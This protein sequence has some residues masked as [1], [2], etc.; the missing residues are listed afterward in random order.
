MSYKCFGNSRAFTR[1]TLEE[2]GGNGSFLIS[3]GFLQLLRSPG[4][5]IKFKEI[6]MGFF[7]FRRMLRVVCSYRIVE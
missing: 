7:E 2:T 4:L 3:K 6:S 5:A 1:L